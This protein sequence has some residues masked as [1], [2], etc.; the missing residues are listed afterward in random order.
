MALDEEEFTYPSL[1][2]RWRRERATT[3]LGKMDNGFYE[4][5]DAHLRALREEYARENAANPA[6]PKVLILQ[7]ELAKLQSVRDDLYDLRERKIVTAA[8]IAAR[9]GHADKA[10]LTRE[11]E[12]VFDELL[13]ALREARRSLLR[14]GQPPAVEAPRPAPAGP[15]M[16]PDP[17]PAPAVSAQPA[18]TL[19]ER[20]PEAVAEAPLAPP[21]PAREEPPLAEALAAAAEP[22]PVRRVGAARMLVRVTSAF[23]PFVGP[24]LRHYSLAAEDVAALPKDVAH[25]LIQRGVAVAVGG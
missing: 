21:A 17:A 20:P 12:I 15:P 2:N 16:A 23:G 6:T 3:A 25:V 9:G 4:A 5:F 13:R 18:S 8:L 22:E 1:V 19:A 11:E 14:R 7:D 24:D 10:T